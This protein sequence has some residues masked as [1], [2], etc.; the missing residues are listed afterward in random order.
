MEEVSDDDLNWDGLKD[1]PMI[2]FP[3]NG[4]KWKQYSE[5]PPTAAGLMGHLMDL[6]IPT[7]GIWAH[8]VLS[9]K[10]SDV[11]QK[12]LED[13]DLGSDTFF[14]LFTDKEFRRF[15]DDGLLKFRDLV[16]NLHLKSEAD[17][18]SS[19]QMTLEAAQPSEEEV[20]S[21]L[22]DLTKRIIGY[23]AGPG[24]F[25]ARQTNHC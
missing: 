16:P 11:V 4:S 8:F 7:E 9:T 21:I 15:Q 1:I 5:D 18:Q 13:P 20:T 2:P 23:K 17:A 25:F 12:P 6:N 19:E 3:F 14:Y 10:A 24:L 22:V